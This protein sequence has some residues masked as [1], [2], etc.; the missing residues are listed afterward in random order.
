LNETLHQSPPPAIPQ[1]NHSINR[2]FTRAGPEA[3]IY[4]S[5][6]G[7]R[8]RVREDHLACALGVRRCK[9]FSS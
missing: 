9:A 4:D 2:V 1:G 8:G 3:V 6:N 7:A 5:L